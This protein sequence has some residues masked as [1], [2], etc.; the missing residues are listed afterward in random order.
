MCHA[1]S[2]SAVWDVKLE[3]YDY[4]LNAVTGIFRSCARVFF[5]LFMS[6]RPGLLSPRV[7]NN[8]I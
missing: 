5:L 3:P 6:F 8:I 1:A 4:V 2:I 7:V